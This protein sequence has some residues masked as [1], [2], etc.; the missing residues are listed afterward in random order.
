MNSTV[1]GLS[2]RVTDAKEHINYQ[3]N[4]MVE[5]TVAEQNIEKK[6]TQMNLFTK[7]K[8][9]HRLR[10][11]CGYQGKAGRDSWGVWD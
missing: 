6:M 8:K 10:R 4:R 1:K 5:I 3:E 7:Q 11:L 2:S 9:T